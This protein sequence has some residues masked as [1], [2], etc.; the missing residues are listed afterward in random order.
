MLPGDWDQVLPARLLAAAG[1]PPSRHTDKKTLCDVQAEPALPSVQ[2]VKALA[3][4]PASGVP[5]HA[6]A[7]A[8]HV[9]VTCHTPPAV[10]R[11]VMEALAGCAWTPAA[12]VVVHCL[13]VVRR[14]V[15]VRL[16]QGMALATAG[17]ASVQRV[18]GW[19][20]GV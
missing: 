6:A 3:L 17:G 4:A 7:A 20:E 15:Q 14:D 2:F 11:A 13:L 18:T 12:Q 5:L 9:P 16:F 1:V 10:Q 8:T 19:A